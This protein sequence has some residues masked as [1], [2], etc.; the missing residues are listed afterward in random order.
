MILV[1]TPYRISFFGGGSDYP[2]WYKKNYGEVLSTTIDKYIYLNFNSIPKFFNHNFRLSYAKIEEVN[3]INEIKHNAIRE[4]LR[5]KNFRNGINL[6]YAGDLPGRSGMGSS[7]SFVVSLINGLNY[8]KKIKKTKYQLAK[9]SIFFEQKILKEVVGIQDQISVTYG[10]FNYI[11][12]EKDNFKV[13]PVREDAFLQK[14]NRNLILIYTGKQRFSYEI[15]RKFVGKLDNNKR[16]HILEILKLVSI[17]RKLIQNKNTESFGYLLEEGWKIKKSLEKSISNS[18]L[19]QIYQK[20]K[21]NGS[22]GGK[23]LGAGAGGF[24][25]FYVPEEKQKYFLKRMQ[26]LINVPFNFSKNGTIVQ[27]I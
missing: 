24:F 3:K 4:A 2:N 5:I 15:A 16:A 18:N 26:P 9:E 11:S 14:L 12:F 27:A 20:A 17:S 8:L 13:K 6:H 21:A 19:D 1:K 23:L 7:S 25:L 10:G 22:I